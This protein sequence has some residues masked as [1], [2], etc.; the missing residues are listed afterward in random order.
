MLRAISLAA[1][2]ALLP[3]SGMAEPI[4]G[5]ASVIDG[6]T[7]EVRG[8]RIRLHGMDAP[9]SRQTCEDAAGRAYRC[10]QRAAFHLADL[11]GAGNITCEERDRDR[12][13]RI[14][15][16]CFLR[17]GTDLGAVM[18]EAGHALAFRRYSRA[19]VAAEEAAQAARRGMWAGSF[20]APW[21][22]RRAN[23]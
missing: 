4:V 5:R 14:V 19:Y 20:L 7:I 8:E 23:R 3:L 6:D 1:L 12:W 13:G 21:D 2:L 17:D 22:W 9:E 11:I 10:G 16:T 15:A 18:V